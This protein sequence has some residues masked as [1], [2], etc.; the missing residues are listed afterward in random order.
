[1]MTRHL[2][3]LKM[4]SEKTKEEAERLA[5]L[6]RNT[7]TIKHMFTREDNPRCGIWTKAGENIPCL[8][9]AQHK[10]GTWHGLTDAGKVRHFRADEVF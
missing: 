2:K 3:E 10:S 8:V 4:I 9:A 7:A 6:W 5:R 1:M